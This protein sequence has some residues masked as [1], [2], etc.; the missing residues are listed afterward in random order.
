MALDS[1]EVLR[2]HCELMRAY[3][4]GALRRKDSSHMIVYSE[5]AKLP[6]ALF[7]IASIWCSVVLNYEQIN[8]GRHMIDFL[9]PARPPRGV[10]GVGCRGPNGNGHRSWWLAN[11]TDWWSGVPDWR[12]TVGNAGHE[13][14]AIEMLIAWDAEGGWQSEGGKSE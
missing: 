4:L 11:R 7:A 3:Y 6:F 12:T 1:S 5:W 10:Q 14:G 13:E 2:K 8:A 9:G